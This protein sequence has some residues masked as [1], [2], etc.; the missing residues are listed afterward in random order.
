MIF[1]VRASVRASVHRPSVRPSVLRP[2]AS[3]RVRQPARRFRRTAGSAEPPNHLLER[4]VP[5][6]FCRFRRDCRFR[7]FRRF[8]QIPD[9]AEAPIPAILPIPAIPLICRIRR[10]DPEST[11]TT[12]TA[13]GRTVTEACTNRRYFIIASPASIPEHRQQPKPPVG[14]PSEPSDQPNHSRR[15][16]WQKYRKSQKRR[17][18]A[19]TPAVNRHRKFRFRST[20]RGEPGSSAESCRFCQT[21]DSAEPWKPPLSVRHPVRPT[22]PASQPASSQTFTSSNIVRDKLT[23]RAWGRAP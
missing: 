13:N 12:A 23:A 21:V 9:F 20:R 17:R 7:Q 18:H 4:A 14:T 11:P 10:T 2:S 8:H 22:Q 19:A 16:K 15:R 5:S 1:F 3:S 6:N